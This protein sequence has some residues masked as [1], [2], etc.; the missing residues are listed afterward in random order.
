MA[1]AYNPFVQ[2]WYQWAHFVALAVA[3]A[4]AF[5]IFYDAAQRGIEAML[6]K[7]LSLAGVIMVL[8]S[9]ALW[10]IPPTHLGSLNSALAPFAYVG[11]GS[12]T[13]AL[14]ALLLHLA[15]IRVD[16]QEVRC[17]R[18][19]ERLHPSWA[20]CP[21]CEAA[22]KQRQ[23]Q[24]AEQ[25]SPDPIPPERVEPD[26]Q[27]DRQPAHIASAPPPD[28]TVERVSNPP[29]S[30]APTEV[31]NR[32]PSNLAWLVLLTGMR[33]GKEFRLGEV[34]KIGRNPTKNDIVL[35]DGAVSR[36]HAKIKKE[37][38]AFLIYDLASTCGTLIKDQESEEWEERQKHT[39]QNG[40]RIK[41]GREVLSFIQ[42]D[43]GQD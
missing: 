21:Y 42:V 16:R 9:L 43:G 41:L 37:G 27:P 36:E 4:S 26:R 5:W 28:P 35:D 29:G 11:I 12:T 31:L 7:V 19:G 17:P 18:C 34:T 6:W 8:P 30:S 33:E 10:A 38:E 23:P 40:D 22:D 39:L 25:P 3:S 1:L 14:L 13:L 32:K 15:G 2:T 20:Y 24:R